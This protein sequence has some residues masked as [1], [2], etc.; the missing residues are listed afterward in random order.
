MPGT[1]VRDRVASPDNR[2]FQVVFLFL[3]VLWYLQVVSVTSAPRDSI[4]PP[5]RQN[6][7]NGALSV[8]ASSLLSNTAKVR[9]DTN[10]ALLL[11]SL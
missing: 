9:G 2:M 10:Q 11:D 1:G 4:F 7:S 8:A 5:V 3:A 6:T